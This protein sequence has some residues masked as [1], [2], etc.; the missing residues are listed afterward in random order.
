MTPDEFFERWRKAWDA[1]FD[2]SPRDESVV[3]ARLEPDKSRLVV[4]VDRGN[5]TEWNAARPTTSTDSEDRP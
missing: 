3:T 4:T 5:A 2:V 1:Q